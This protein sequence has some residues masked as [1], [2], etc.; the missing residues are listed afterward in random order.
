M[1]AREEAPPP[2]EPATGPTGSGSDGVMAQLVTLLRAVAS[3][4]HR[5]RLGLLAAGVTAVI[6]LNAVAQVRLN[7]WQGAFY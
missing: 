1:N 3:S 6:C 2:Q 7:S 4:R 5:R